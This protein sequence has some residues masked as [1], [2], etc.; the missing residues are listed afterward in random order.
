MLRHSDIWLGLDRLARRHGL[1]PSALARRA[2][3]DP[4]TFNPSKRQGA[5]GRDR[6][7]TT[8]SLAKALTATGTSLTGFGLLVEAG[9]QA[10]ALPRTLP[11]APALGLDA[12][13][14]DADGVSTGD[15]W[16]PLVA[17]GLPT[18]D[19]PRAFALSVTGDS[20]CPELTDG[21]LVIASPAASLRVG[22]RV[23]VVAAGRP[24][25]LGGLAGLSV[26]RIQLLPFGPYPRGESA[27]PAVVI[28][29][30]E[31]RLVARILWVR[32]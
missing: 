1:T 15:S 20:F 28:A 27:V 30:Q 31:L 25:V 23:V 7:P 11:M 21:S 13:A 12:S 5:A 24:A 14:F 4:T 26:H 3:L 8:E 18:V 9:E 16:G 10:A 29:Q 22:D 6:W 32:H 19:D 2:G 17:A